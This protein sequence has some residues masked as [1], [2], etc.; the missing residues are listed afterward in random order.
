MFKC[1]LLSD[2]ILNQKSAT[3]GN[4]E[5]LDFI[6]GNNFLGIVAS[7]LYNDELDREK[8]RILFHSKEVRFGDGHPANQN[9]RSLKIPA[10]LFYPKLQNPFEE[11]YVQYLIPNPS[12]DSMKKKE[13]KQC[14]N[15]FY[16]FRDNNAY[17]V[18]IIKNYAIKS[19]YDK[20][21]RRSKD[22]QMYGYESLNKGMNYFFEVTI[23]ENAMEFENDIIEALV[24]LKRIGRSRTAQYGLVEISE[25]NFNEVQSSSECFELE[26]KKYFSI[27]AEG[28]LI[29]LDKYG[30]PT[31]QPSAADLGIPN[32]EIIWSKSQIRTFQY[33]PWNYKRMT[34]DADRCGIEKG[35]VFVVEL[36]DDNVNFTD[37]GYVGYYQNEGFGKVIYNPSFLKADLNTGMTVCKIQKNQEID[38]SPKIEKVNSISSSLLIDYLESR[39][40]SEDC[41]SQIYESVNKFINDNMKL[42]KGDVFASQWG[43][44]RS[45]AMKYKTVDEIKN[46][47]YLKKDSDGNDN[48][49]L[50]HGLAFDKWNRNGRLKVF[51]DFVENT[52]ED[53]LRETIINL[54]TE[55][56]KACKKK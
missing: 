25:C 27:Y 35:S 49:Y 54:A 28:R 1:E 30:L 13:L 47:L 21:A 2:V 38:H 31:F 56:S 5:T 29:F 44:I 37:P 48:A 12:S 4:R 18:D 43:T 40:K 14:R 39:K 9:D 19:A 42:Y 6:P 8:A 33:A 15:G 7:Q 20:I 24:G 10:S 23:D 16:C 11:C 17:E 22:K 3:E 55:M 51:K 41:L 50:T 34:Y 26:G 32:G 52:S 36:L 46:E 45:I 53:I